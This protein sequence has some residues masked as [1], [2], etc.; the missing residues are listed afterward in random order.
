[1]NLTEEGPINVPNRPADALKRLLCALFDPAAE[2]AVPGLRIGMLA[3]LFAGGLILW[4]FFFNWGSFPLNFHDWGEVNAPRLAFLKNAVSS[5]ALPL[6]MPS[7]SA[8]R[9]VTD[10]YLSLPDIL[11]S[12]QGILLAVLQVGPF[13]LVNFLLLYAAGFWG[14]LKLRKKFSLSLAVFAILFFLFNFNG[15]IVA[16]LSV[17]HTT[18]GGYFLFPWLIWLLVRVLDGDHSWRIVLEAALLLLLIFLQGSS[19]HFTWALMFAGLLA[20]AAWKH[21]P[22]IFKILLFGGLLAMVRMLPVALMLGQFDTEFLGG[23]PL[24]RYMAAALVLGKTPADAMPFQNFYSSLGYWEFDLYIGIAGVLLLG[25]GLALWLIRQAR[26]RKPS[27]W[28][29]PL[30]V[31]PFLSMAN[32]YQ[33]LA[34][35]PIPLLSGE[36]VTSRLII[37][38]FVAALVWSSAALSQAL[39]QANASAWLRGLVLVALFGLAVDLVHHTL[40]WQVLRSAAAFP[41]I[42]LDLTR[43]VIAN[44][45]DPAYTNSLWIGAAISLAALAVLGFLAWR[46]QHTKAVR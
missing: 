3:A 22:A 9:G 20:L 14:L 46:E 41:S 39:A 1:M 42:A 11:L 17:G 5:L 19:H 44:H 37:L 27:P 8:L 34:F 40:Q 31:M 32:R 26:E 45:L 23:Y 13:I 33:I 2:N 7:A 36:R 24:M 29:L 38:P 30:V 43:Q 21:L 12:P 25:A 10:R 28:L 15:H 4:G 18:W 35:L 6:H 16:H